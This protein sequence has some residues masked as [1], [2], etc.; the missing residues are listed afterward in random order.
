MAH[1]TGCSSRCRAGMRRSTT[2]EAG[3]SSRSTWIDR[4][5]RSLRERTAVRLW[6]IRGHDGDAKSAR[7]ASGPPSGRRT[8]IVALREVIALGPVVDDAAPAI[9]APAAHH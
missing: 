7:G 3:R 1:C 6:L 4:V 9:G 5:V 8:L 2:T